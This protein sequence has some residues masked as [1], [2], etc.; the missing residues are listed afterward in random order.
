MGVLIDILYEDQSNFDMDDF[1]QLAR[2]MNRLFL[3]HDSKQEQIASLDLSRMSVITKTIMVALLMTQK[4]GY[5]IDN[6]QFAELK[7]IQPFEKR[8]NLVEEPANC[9]EWLLYY[10]IGW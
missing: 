3:K 7:N 2:N 5:L 1:Y 10:N 9:H 8:F 6:P 4:K